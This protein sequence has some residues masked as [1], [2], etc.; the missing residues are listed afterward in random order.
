MGW[1]EGR[2]ETTVHNAKYFYVGEGIKSKSKRSRPSFEMLKAYRNDPNLPTTEQLRSLYYDY[3]KEFRNKIISQTDKG[4][5]N[6]KSPNNKWHSVLPKNAV[7]INATQY[8]QLFGN[9]NLIKVKKG[10]IKFKPIGKDGRGDDH[11][12]YKFTI[13]Q[14]DI[15]LKFNNKKVIIRYDFDDMSKA[16][17]FTQ[18][19]EFIAMVDPSPVV[20]K[21]LLG[22]TS[23]DKLN[24]RIH[25][26]GKHKLITDLNDRLEVLKEIES[27][28]ESRKVPIEVLTH[29]DDKDAADVAHRDYFLEM[30]RQAEIATLK[31]RDIKK[32]KESINHNN[33][34]PTSMRVSARLTL[35]NYN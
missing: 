15:F 9:N 26:E 4:L 20:R 19:E 10:V 16:Y 29:Y 3:Q 23:K 32:T 21:N 35:E 5:L 6:G 12:V 24:L 1:Q 7:H 2:V 27:Q 11:P 25:K 28:F 13:Y 22:Q 34:I 18:Q 14:S 8:V 30:T 17:L 33:Y 31:K